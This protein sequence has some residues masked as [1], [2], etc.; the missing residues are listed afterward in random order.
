[1]DEFSIDFKRT[2]KFS[3]VN[4][5]FNENINKLDTIHKKKYLIDRIIV[6]V[7]NL[8]HIIPVLFGYIHFI[9]IKPSNLIIHIYLYTK[10]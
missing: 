6:I 9:Q 4:S 7:I 8:D 5:F 10:S 3:V 2:D 1:M